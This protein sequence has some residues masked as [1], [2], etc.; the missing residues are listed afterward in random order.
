MRKM[1]IHRTFKFKLNTNK[2]VFIFTSISVHNT[3]RCKKKIQKKL[4]HLFYFMMF[5]LPTKE[6]S[7]KIISIW[8]IHR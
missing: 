3:L 7:I 8:S 1:D 6:T 2:V 4:A 5:G